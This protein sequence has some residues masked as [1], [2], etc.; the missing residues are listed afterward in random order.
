MTDGTGVALTAVAAVVVA[1]LVVRARASS[2]KSTWATSTVNGVRYRVLDLPD[3]VAAADALANLE[4]AASDFLDAADRAAPGDRRLANVRRRWSRRLREI[5]GSD[6]IAYTT[7]KRDISIC[8]RAED[9]SVYATRDSMFV[10]LHELA[11]IAS[12]AWG[13]G[14]SYWTDFRFILELADSV[15]AYTYQNFD[16]SPVTY[17]GKAITDSPLT[18]VKDG[19]C[20][21]NI[22]P[23]RPTMR[24]T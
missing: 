15:G 23:I 13:H 4:I 6:N 2:S 9:G 3:A 12:D 20:A 16:A 22:R 21:S 24:P 5:D 14:E 18:C 8:V 19:T 7:T 17:C 11:H 1:W 10:L